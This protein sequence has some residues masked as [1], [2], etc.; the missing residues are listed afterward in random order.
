MHSNIPASIAFWGQ[1]AVCWDNPK[2]LKVSGIF[3]T[4]ANGHPLA[5]L[6]GIHLMEQRFFVKLGTEI[7]LFPSTITRTVFAVF[8]IILLPTTSSR[9]CRVT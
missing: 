7:L 3:L 4:S 5:M 9:I 8:F 6:A 2:P 1:K